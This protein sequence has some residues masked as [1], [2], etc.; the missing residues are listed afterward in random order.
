MIGVAV[1]REARY[2]DGAGRGEV[3]ISPDVPH[4]VW[5][6]VEA[7]PRSVAGSAATKHEGSLAAHRVAR[8]SAVASRTT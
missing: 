5:R 7:E 2:C 6:L 4:C 8:L 1:N 3:L